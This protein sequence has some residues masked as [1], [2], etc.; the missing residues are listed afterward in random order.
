MLTKSADDKSPR[1]ALL[2]GLLRQSHLSPSQR[3]WV[4]EELMRLRKGIEGER[5]AAHYLDSYFKDGQNHVVLHD[6]RFEVDGETAQ[7][8]HLVLNRGIGMYLIETKNY[9][10]NLII[11]EH[12]EFTVDYDGE[13]FGVP[14]PIEQSKRHERVLSKLMDRL[15]LNARMGERE[16]YHVVLLHP[17][18]KIERPAVKAFD[19]SMVIKADQFP[20]WHQSFVDKSLGLGSFVKAIANVRSRETMTDWAEKL[21]R[22]HRPAD[23]L[24]LPNFM[25]SALNVAT[26]TT[27]APPSSAPPVPAKSVGTSV[28]DSPPI[29]VVASV[30]HPLARKL[31]CVSC[32]EK[33]SYAEGKF[34]WNSAKRFGGLQY[35][36]EH[37]TNF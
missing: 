30:D 28:V 1:V 2:T 8:D 22:Q 24:S 27:S 10:G 25:K 14:S 35:C 13:R 23:L 11:N 7:I 31:V 12:G 4:R 3:K 15:D 17:K 26:P 5:Q 18:A 37:Q 29:A 6:L 20:T 21:M 19:T 34:C 36:R 32:G 9:A 16:F 33:I